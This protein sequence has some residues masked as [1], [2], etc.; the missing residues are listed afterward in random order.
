MK[1]KKTQIEGIEKVLSTVGSCIITV[2]PNAA[3]NILPNLTPTIK[4]IG[5]NIILPKP[6][7]LNEE[8][9]V[10]VYVSAKA[11]GDPFPPADIA[12]F[13]VEPGWHLTGIM[14]EK[15]GLEEDGKKETK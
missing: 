1:L 7:L 15:E 9:D 14:G 10:T 11:I 5:N 6:L 3:I 12:S 13:E 2:M 8:Q 4:R